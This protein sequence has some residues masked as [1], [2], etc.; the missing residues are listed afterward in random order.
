MG[1]VASGEGDAV[2]VVFGLVKGE[3]VGDDVAGEEL[4]VVRWRSAERRYSMGGDWRCSLR[5]MCN[6]GVLMA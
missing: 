6:G 3:S 1:G 2:G 5:R 4:W